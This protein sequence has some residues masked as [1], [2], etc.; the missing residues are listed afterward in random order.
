MAKKSKIKIKPS[1]R[2]SFTSW[3]K[4]KGYGGVTSTCIAAG[5]RSKSASIRKKATFA[6]N[7]RG[8]GR[9]KRK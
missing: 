5:K 1:R 7:A 6:G 4:R 8:W 3:C 2:G 9:T